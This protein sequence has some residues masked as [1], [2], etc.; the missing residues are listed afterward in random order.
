MLCFVPAGLEDADEFWEWFVACAYFHH[1]DVE[2][3]RPVGELYIDL[4]ALWRRLEDVFS[5][6]GH[7]HNSFVWQTGISSESR[8]ADALV[9]R[10]LG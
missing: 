1:V 5:H 3:V 7:H 10:K 8:S 9:H 6:G 4:V 2:D